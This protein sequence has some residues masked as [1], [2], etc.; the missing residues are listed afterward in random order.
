MI[1]CAVLISNQKT[2]DYLAVLVLEPS[3]ML[4]TSTFRGGIHPYALKPLI[5]A[6]L[7][8][9]IYKKYADVLAQTKVLPLELMRFETGRLVDLINGRSMTLG[10]VLVSARAVEREDYHD[11]SV[12]D[13]EAPRG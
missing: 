13:S 4:V 8:E 3:G 7:D 10:G 9:P 2:G 5:G 12:N 6:L 1:Q 11:E